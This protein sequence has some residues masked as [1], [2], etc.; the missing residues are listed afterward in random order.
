MFHTRMINKEQSVPLG[1]NPKSESNKEAV[2][3]LK[4]KPKSI[5]AIMKSKVKPSDSLLYLPDFEEMITSDTKG[6][7]KPR[8][9]YHTIVVN[10]FHPDFIEIQVRLPQNCLIVDLKHRV[11][12]ILG[13]KIDSID[14]FGF[15]EGTLGCPVQH[16][17]DDK[18][19]QSFTNLC[20]MR[21]SFDRNYEFNATEYDNVALQLLYYELANMVK[22]EKL[23]SR[24]LDQG[25]I[26]STHQCCHSRR[27]HHFVRSA[28]EI[29]L[30]CLL[31]LILPLVLLH[32]AEFLQSY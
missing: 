12:Y 27:T 16:I 10:T 24:T 11:K 1:T 20:F 23:A 25:H 19:V 5:E 13:L 26:K 30:S 6:E 28:S 3:K 2:Q 32:S 31:G 7:Q 14:M 15:F 21:L 4:V 17:P 8:V 29:P 22:N 9:R 18:P